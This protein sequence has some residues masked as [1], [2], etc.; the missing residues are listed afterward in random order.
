MQIGLHDEIPEI[1]LNISEILKDFIQ[2]CLKRDPKERSDAE[3][4]LKHK[5]LENVEI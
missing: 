2:A 1:P 5:F 4:L 3:S